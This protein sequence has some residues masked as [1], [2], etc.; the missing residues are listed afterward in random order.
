MEDAGVW[1]LTLI[2]MNFDANM[3][4][5]YDSSSVDLALLL[6][7]YIEQL[8]MILSPKGGVR[9]VKLTAD[10]RS[11]FFDNVVALQ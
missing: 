11:V 5:D 3:V 1:T 7:K 8:D 6:I 10:E 2:C 9:K 4:R